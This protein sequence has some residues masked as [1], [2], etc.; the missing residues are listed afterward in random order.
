MRKRTP[1]ALAVGVVPVTSQQPRNQFD[2]VL[3][4]WEDAGLL[5]PS[6]ARTT[7]IISIHGS[8]LKHQ[9]GSL[10]EHD[11][12]KVLHMCGVYSSIHWY[13]ITSNNF[14]CTLTIN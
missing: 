6:V 3:E 1:L 10:Q 14:Y 11:L 2:V 5:K 8:E 12:E 7:K 4:F 9:L 13:L